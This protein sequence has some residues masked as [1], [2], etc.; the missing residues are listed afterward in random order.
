M[1]VCIQNILC[2]LYIICIIDCGYNEMFKLH[3]LVEKKKLIFKATM[4]K[5]YIATFTKPCSFMSFFL[6]VIAVLTPQTLSF[7]GK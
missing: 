4:A 2:A 5:M 6:C 1:W 7:L 3:R